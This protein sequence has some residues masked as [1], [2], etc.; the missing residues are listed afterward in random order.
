HSLADKLCLD[1]FY[2]QDNDYRGEPPPERYAAVI[3]ALTRSLQSDGQRPTFRRTW[4]HQSKASWQSLTDLPTKVRIDNSTSDQFTIIDVFAHDRPGL[5]YTIARALYELRLSVATAR[6]GTYLDQV[7][8]VFYVTDTRGLK[9][10][11]ESRITE[12][13]EA[14]LEAIAMFENNSI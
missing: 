7:V 6:I 13:R 9:I 2:V 4:Q 11:D 14:L 12:I 10:G 3:R 1:R 8:D 5:L